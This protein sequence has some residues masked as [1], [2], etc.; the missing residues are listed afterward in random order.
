MTKHY[1]HP[2][3]ELKNIK[4]SEF[5]SQETNCYEA[6]LYLDGKK[7]GFVGNQGHGGCDRFDSVSEAAK[8]SL[9]SFLETLPPVELGHGLN[10]V[11]PGLDQLE[12]LC[13]DIISEWQVEK[14]FKRAMKK[15]SYLKEGSLYQLPTK[16]KPTKDVLSS[17]KR[18]KWFT[19]K[20]ILLNELP[21][22]DAY[23]Q[24]RKVVLVS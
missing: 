4:F 19:N 22:V 11:Q 21:T 14:E 9:V 7:V 6:T 18:A 3:L 8:L 17:V 16:Y 23:N 1:T 24:L 20:C 2:G 5:A 13:C 15:V 12:M 10:P